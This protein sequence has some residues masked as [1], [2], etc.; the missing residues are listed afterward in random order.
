M[1]DHLHVI[2]VLTFPKCQFFFPAV[3]Y[4]Q[5][6]SIFDFNFS[7]VFNFWRVTT[8]S[9]NVPEICKSIF[10]YVVIVDIVDIVDI[11]FCHF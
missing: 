5:P 1:F 6:L 7:V 10:C 9:E 8:Q 11:V 3:M 4:L 2:P